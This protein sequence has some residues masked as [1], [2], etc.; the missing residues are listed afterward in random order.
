MKLTI[1]DNTFTVKLAVTPETIKNGMMG[2]RFD[3][4]FNGLF[5]LMGGKEQQCFWMKNCIIP[6]DIIMIDGDTITEIHK[7]C[8]PCYEEPCESYCG[9]GDRVLEV[10]GG[11]CD[12]LNIQVGDEVSFSIF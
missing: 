7:N 6:L 1:N 3:E 10:Y 4:T 9:F 2:K 12:N 8:P 5:F 11:T